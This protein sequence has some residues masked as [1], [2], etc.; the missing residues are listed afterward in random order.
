AEGDEPGR[1][2]KRSLVEFREWVQ[3]S[4]R[5][6]DEWQR[7]VDGRIRHVVEGISPFPGLQ[8]DV[9]ALAARIA[10]PEAKLEQIAEDEPLPP[11]GDGRLVE[12]PAKNAADGVRPDAASGETTN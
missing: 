5:T 1:F 11:R 7:R 9:K 2:G 3:Q 4:Q 6:I 8:K 12:M 10:E